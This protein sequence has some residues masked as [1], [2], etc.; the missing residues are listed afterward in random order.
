[1]AASRLANRRAGGLRRARAVATARP[2]STAATSRVCP[3][4]SSARPLQ[5]SRVRMRTALT[6][7]PLTLGS[8]SEWMPTPDQRESGAAARR[9]GSGAPRSSDWRMEPARSAPPDPTASDLGRWK[10][11]RARGSWP[12]TESTG[13]EETARWGSLR[14]GGACSHAWCRRLVQARADCASGGTIRALHPVPYRR[15]R[16]P[17]HRFRSRFTWIVGLRSSLTAGTV[18]GLRIGGES[19][20]D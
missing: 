1:M 6:A 16:R 4:W 8:R 7:V 9:S 15:S 18:D 2:H 3:R 13:A 5:K 12:P 19:R 20:G 10:N 17:P 11:R 14:V